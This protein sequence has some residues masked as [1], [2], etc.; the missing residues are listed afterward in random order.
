[1]H[2]ICF[3]GEVLYAEHGQLL[4]DVLM[5]GEKAMEHPCGG[6]GVCK[7]CAVKV[8]GEEV[9]SCQYKVESDIA[10]E[11]PDISE[12]HSYTG[13]EETLL[14]SKN[15]CF[16]LDLGTTTLALALVSLDEKKIVKVATA[17]NPQRL[18]GG[19]V[20][21]RI[22]YCS[23]NGVKS[24]QKMVVSKI[25]EMMS[26]LFKGFIGKMYV[27]GN[28]T[29]LHILFGADC[30]GLGV[31]PYKA[32]FLHSRVAS[33]QTLGIDNVEEITALPSIHTFAGADI[34][35]GLNYI[36][37]PSHDKYSLLVDLGTNAEIAL[38]SD[39]KVVC[40]SAAAGP[41]FE[42]ANISCG[43]SA[44]GGAIYSY[45]NSAYKTIGGK[46]AEGLCATG[47]VDVIAEL[48]SK[49]II[50]E[51]GYMEG[52]FQI[53][54]GVTLTCGDVREYQLAK[55]AISSAI[56]V[57][58]DENKVDNDHLY[59]V[60]ISGGFSEKLNIENAVKSGLLPEKIASECVAVNN[61]SLSGT[62]KYACEHNDLTEFI[63]KSEY[64]DLSSNEKFS[65]MFIENMMFSLT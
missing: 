32:E 22:A 24:L 28:T 48:L 46:K 56:N 61:S 65:E 44:V 18:Y 16:C 31:A 26:S 50:D 59:K 8:N 53:A 19:D 4:A 5:K 51:T 7:K 37:K 60:Y 52:D 20:M 55:S 12:I 47:L 33:G 62:V 27:A 14:S 41:C 21:S 34:V 1:M 2:K 54:P 40:T 17:T 45:K 57:L 49:G 13:A 10:V 15:M 9:L 11:A 30:S 25:N 35:A 38:F 43:M 64:V 23:A 63:K 6:R 36:E 58:L 29:M 39:E 42:G 3:N